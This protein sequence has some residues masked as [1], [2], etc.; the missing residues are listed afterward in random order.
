[1]ARSVKRRMTR[2]QE[3]VIREWTKKPGTTDWP[4]GFSPKHAA[5]L[6][7]DELDRR[8]QRSKIQAAT[9]GI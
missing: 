8:R 2:E 7:L 4:K 5:R 3:Q 1:M 9:W 6:L